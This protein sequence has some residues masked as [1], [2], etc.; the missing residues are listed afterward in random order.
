MGA[1]DHLAG[2][3]A[4]KI[5]EQE[6]SGAVLSPPEGIPGDT[7]CPPVP[8]LST[9]RQHRTVGGHP[10]HGALCSW[11]CVLAL[12]SVLSDRQPSGGGTEASVEIS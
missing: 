12:G 5:R 6:A 1:R 10:G 7:H 2:Q 11:S 9:L 4:R 3:A 8:H